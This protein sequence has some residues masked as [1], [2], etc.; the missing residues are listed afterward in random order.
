MHNLERKR[1]HTSLELS[2]DAVDVVSVLV[3]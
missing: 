2:R 1:L 3:F